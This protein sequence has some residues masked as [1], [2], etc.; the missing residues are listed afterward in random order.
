MTDTAEVDGHSK[1]TQPKDAKAADAGMLGRLARRLRQA[2]G[3]KESGVYVTGSGP[4]WVPEAR[5][6]E[7]PRV[8]AEYHRGEAEEASKIAK[9]PKRWA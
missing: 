5:L 9:L 4:V 6:S 3:S 7:I 1:S 8:I 2:F